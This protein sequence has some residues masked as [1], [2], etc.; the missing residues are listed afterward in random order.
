MVGDERLAERAG[1]S[2]GG[3]TAK[4]QRLVMELGYEVQFGAARAMQTVAGAG[5]GP[6]NLDIAATRGQPRK[7]ILKPSDGAV[8]RRRLGRDRG[9]RG[10]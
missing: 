9:L 8:T 4:L 6:L 5:H 3:Q 7:Q 1:R 10:G 2:R